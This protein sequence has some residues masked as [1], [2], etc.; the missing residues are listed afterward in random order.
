MV[1]V[2]VDN[3]IWSDHTDIQP[4]M[5]ALLGLADDYAPDGVVLSDVIDSLALPP[6]MLS[7][8][9]LLVQLGQVYT[10]LEAAVGEFGLG[11][12]TASTR[13]LASDSAGDGTYTTIENQLAQLGAARDAL[14]AQM[15]AA[16]L[17]A[18]FG[19]QP[20]DGHAARK[21]VAAGQGLLAQAD[22]LA[23]GP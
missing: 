9:P 18:E 5:L 21:L 22:A 20:L 15:Q 11:T 10:Q 2:G 14:A 7:N 12:L 6:A 19:G 8:Y 23:A 17:G 4:T 16:L 13:A 1:N 3:S